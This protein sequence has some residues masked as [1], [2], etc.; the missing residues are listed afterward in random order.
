MDCEMQ[1]LVIDNGSS[2]CR[3]GFAGD[4]SP[5]SVFNSIASVVRRPKYARPDLNAFYVGDDAWRKVD[6]LNLRWPIE[7]GL[8]TNWDEMEQ[9]W[10][11]AF[12]NELHVDP[13]ECSILL[14]D[15]VLNPKPNRKKMAQIM[16]ETFNVPSFYV[17]CQA[18]LSLFSSGRATGIVVE[19][20][21]GVTQIVPIYEGYFL[22]DTITRMNFAGSDLTEYLRT[23]LI[24]KYNFDSFNNRDIV[25]DIKEKLGYVA[26]DFDAELRKAAITTNCTRSYAIPNGDQ[27]TVA[28]EHFRCP[29][30]LF[31]PSLAGFKFDGIDKALFD[32]LM[33]CNMSLR[34]DL[35]ANIV[36]SG[37]NSMFMGLKERLEKEM[38]RLAF[39]TLKIKVVADADREYGAW[40]GGSIFGA[41][42][43]FPGMAITRERYNDAGP[44]IV[45]TI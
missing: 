37:G 25:R 41:L 28:N 1:V 20:G 36:L 7:H 17:A 34:N 9:I 32:S 30:L 22:P 6:I 24:Q 2:L 29:E 14:T 43:T 31:K 35:C 21:D 19:M 38:R 15:V 33:K 4:E 5:R 10:H 16:F 42:A 12:S 23:I 13:T 45:H 44:A 11:H 18:V 27:I 39:T 26:L 40:I 3:V 8:V